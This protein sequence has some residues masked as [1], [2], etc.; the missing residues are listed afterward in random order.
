MSQA[1]TDLLRGG[2]SDHI[3]PDH[4]RGVTCLAVLG[5][6]QAVA[7]ELDVDADAGMSGQEA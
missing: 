6:G 5:G 2:S 7:A 1:R 4:E 3:P